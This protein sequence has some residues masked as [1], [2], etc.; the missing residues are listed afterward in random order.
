MFEPG[1]WQSQHDENPTDIP[2]DDRS[3][4]ITPCGLL[5]NELIYSPQGILKPIQ[6]F[7]DFAI[8]LDTGKFSNYSSTI[9]LYAVRLVVRVEGYL[10]F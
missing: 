2:S 5:F 8:D 9:I 1:Q 3:H 6:D 7:L 4:L 10:F